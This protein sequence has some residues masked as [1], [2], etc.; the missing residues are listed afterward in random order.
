VVALKAVLLAV[1]DRRMAGMV[2]GLSS[3]FSLCFFL[4]CSPLLLFSSSTLFS[5]V[6]HGAL[7]FHGGSAVVWQRCPCWWRWRGSLVTTIVLSSLQRL[8]LFSFWL[9]LL[10]LVFPSVSCSLFSLA[11]SSGFCHLLLWFFF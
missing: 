10:S 5:S 9:F 7:P 8:P 3:F 6:S 4:L 2:V 11:S 1:A